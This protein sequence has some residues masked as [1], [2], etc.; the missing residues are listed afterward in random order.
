MKPRKT[1]AS[2]EENEK[3]AML[4]ED[5]C[6]SKLGFGTCV[7]TNERKGSKERKQ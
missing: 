3:V 7:R 5:A 6:S 4:V 2:K 1:T